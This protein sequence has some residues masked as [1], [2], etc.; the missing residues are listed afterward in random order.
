MREWITEEEIE[1]A[2]NYL[3]DT[4]KDFAKWKAR[5]KYLELHRKSIRAAEILS[6][7]GNTIGENTQRG[8]ASQAYKDILKEYEEAVYEFTLIDARRNAA[9]SKIS[10]WQTVSSSNRKGHV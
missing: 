8:E 5:M 1:A 7:K 9:E 10:A 6:A 4:A 2:L 3:R